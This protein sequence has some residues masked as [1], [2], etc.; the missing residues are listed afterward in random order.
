MSLFRVGKSLLGTAIAD[1]VAA[2]DQAAIVELSAAPP[3]M[4]ATLRVR[5]IRADGSSFDAE[6]LVAPKSLDGGPMLCVFAEDVTRRRL[7]ERHMSHLAFTDTLTGLP[8]RALAFD[9]LRDAAIDA[10]GG[11]GLAVL[12][13]D[14][15]GLK[16]ANDTFGHQ[17]GD[18][19]LQVT[20]QQFLGCIRNGDTVARLGG[21]EFCVILP[22]LR[23]GHNAEMVAARLV[24]AAGQPISVNGQDVCVGASVGIALFP[25][26]GTTGD[27]LI[28]AAD[29]ALYEAKRGGR[30]RFVSASGLGPVITLPVIT[31]TPTYDVGIA[32]MDRQHRQLAADLSEIAASL[33]R[34]DDETTISGKLAA[35]LAHASHHFECEEQLMAEH[36]FVDAAAHRQSHAHLLDDLRSFSAVRDTRSLSLTARFLQEWLLRHIDGADRRLAEA[37]RARG[38]R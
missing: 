38:I 24:E 1:L 10:R 11:Y 22:R 20:A 34:G 29:V 6:M 14:L 27:A 37:L 12:M 13:A 25:D 5:A 30:G 16:R 19:V 15:D 3:E 21:D 26:H 32:M 9:R 7:A 23:D 28:A 35:A 33:R 4:P 36:G 17:T 18:V 31:W 8:N 2:R